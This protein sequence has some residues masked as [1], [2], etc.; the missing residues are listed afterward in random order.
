MGPG[1]YVTNSRHFWFWV[2]KGGGRFLAFGHTLIPRVPRRGVKKLLNFWPYPKF[3]GFQEG[4]KRLLAFGH[5]LIPRVPRGGSEE[6]ISFW[7]FPNS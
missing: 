2:G 7:P 3:L 5:S 4:V 6:I 1:G